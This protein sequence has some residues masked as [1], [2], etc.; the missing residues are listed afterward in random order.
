[1]WIFKHG[2]KKEVE[3][4]SGRRGYEK[5]IILLPLS[6]KEFIKV[7]DFSLYEKILKI[8]NLE[9][10]KIFKKV[11]EIFPYFNEIQDLFFKYLKIGEFPIA[12]KNEEINQEVKDV[13]WSLIK[14]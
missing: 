6:F 2:V 14:K 5:D 8:E 9:K 12:V 1:M 11:Y 10:D 3:T 7:F 13:Y 4:F